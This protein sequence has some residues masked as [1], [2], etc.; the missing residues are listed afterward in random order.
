[1]NCFCAATAFCYKLFNPGAAHAD[2]GKLRRYKK[3]VK[4]H[5][6]QDRYQTVNPKARGGRLLG[7]GLAGHRIS[8][9]E[10]QNTTYIQNVIILLKLP[11]YTI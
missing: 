4:G 9:A 10:A 6:H 1:L 2:Q 7:L 5:Q 8:R 11:C 3:S